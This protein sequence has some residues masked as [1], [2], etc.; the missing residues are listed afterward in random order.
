M[1]F[2]RVVDVVEYLVLAAAVVFV[3]ALFANEGSTPATLADPTA[4]A[5]AAVFADDCAGCHG[6]DGGGGTGPALAD[7]A[8]VAAFPD[9]E[10]QIEVVSEGRNGMPAFGDRLDPEEIQAVTDYTRDEL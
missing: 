10:D 5:G 1:S 8:V 7:G 3:I 9:P 4:A 2:R 6:A